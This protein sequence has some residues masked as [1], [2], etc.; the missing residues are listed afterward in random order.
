MVKAPTCEKKTTSTTGN[1][2]IQKL[3]CRSKRLERI[4]RD[5]NSENADNVE[6]YSEKLS[7]SLNKLSMTVLINQQNG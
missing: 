4:V 1:D 6:D 3:R 5:R 2:R 7:S